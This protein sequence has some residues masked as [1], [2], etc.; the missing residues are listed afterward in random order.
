[1][2]ISMD[3]FRDQRELLSLLE[4]SSLDKGLL[5]MNYLTSVVLIQEVQQVAE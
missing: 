1:M 4:V 2:I 3:L 5:Q